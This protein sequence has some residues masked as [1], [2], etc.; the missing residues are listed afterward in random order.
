VATIHVGLR[1]LLGGLLV[2]AGARKLARLGETAGALP[3]VLDAPSA[4]GRPLVVAAALVEIAV[5]LG[6]VAGS[7]TASLVA[8][9][10]LAAFA[11]LVARAVLRGNAGA[12]CACFGGSGRLGWPAVARNAVLAAAFAVL[13]FAAGVS[14]TTDGWLALG[15][16]VSLT[17]V[18][19]LALLVLALAREIGL[20]RLQMPPQSA[21]ELES[22]G[23][24]LGERTGVIQRF[25][26]AAGARFAL[27]VFS[28]DGCQLCRSLAPA[29]RAFARDPLVAVE[30]FDEVRDQDVWEELSVP[31][32]PYAVAMGLEG[33]VR[34]KGTFNNLAQLE[35]VVAAA[36]RRELALAAAGA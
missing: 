4:W 10:L 33:T 12:P 17:A 3:R 11:L 23:P 36:E 18:G 31:G 30:V 22:E 6:V 5:G 27:A 14:L 9:G 35:S 15:L 28:S 26:P 13:P 34:A 16:A 20:L 1:L 24:P 29:V 7:A 19:T 8:A 21:L 25:A 2:W 32:S